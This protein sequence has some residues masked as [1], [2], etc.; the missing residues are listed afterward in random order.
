MRL[1]VPRLSRDRLAGGCSGTS[2]KRCMALV[3]LTHVADRVA[4]QHD[5]VSPWR[6][7]AATCHAQPLNELASYEGAKGAVYAN[8]KQSQ[9]ASGLRGHREIVVANK[10]AICGCS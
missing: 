8:N 9:D 7:A 6:R 5:S 10:L 3:W 1:S 4:N 2:G